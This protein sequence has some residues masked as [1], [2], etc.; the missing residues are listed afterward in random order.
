VRLA[1]TTQNQIT[2]GN[3]GN[4]EWSRVPPSSL[5][6]GPDTI[7]WTCSATS[8]FWNETGGVPG[9]HDG[10]ALLAPIDDGDFDLR[11]SAAGLPTSAYDQFGVFLK[12][13][14]VRWIKAGV[15]FDQALWL[16]VVATDR[17]SDWSRERYASSSISVRV[18]RVDGTVRVF[19]ADCGDWRMIRELMLAGS[20]SVGIYSCSPKGEGFPT[21]ARIERA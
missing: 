13:N 10:N 3:L 19:V 20:L 9:V 8:D 2:L 18:T 11:V 17:V 5:A 7:A 16:S 6:L 4:A 1:L 14:D 15:E 12:Q 21:V